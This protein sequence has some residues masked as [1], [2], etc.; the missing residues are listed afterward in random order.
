MTTPIFLDGAPPS[1]SQRQLAVLRILCSWREE[2]ARSRTCPDRRGSRSGAGDGGSQWNL[3][4]FCGILNRCGE[5]WGQTKRQG[6]NQMRTAI[7][8]HPSGPPSAQCCAAGRKRCVPDPETSPPSSPICPA[9]CVGASC[10]GRRRPTRRT[11]F[12]LPYLALRSSPRTGLAVRQDLTPPGDPGRA[13]RGRPDSTD[14]VHRRIRW[15][16]VQSPNP[17]YRRDRGDDPLERKF[18]LEMGNLSKRPQNDRLEYNLLLRL[19]T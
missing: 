3:R 15:Y 1:L 16:R 8:N 18:D 4:C 9:C 13:H 2:D 7:E 12:P 11:P 5:L 14:P 17:C 19:E 10:C 6:D